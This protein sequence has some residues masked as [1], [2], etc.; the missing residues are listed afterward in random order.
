MKRLPV[1]YRLNN[2]GNIDHNPRN[3]WQGLNDPPY[4]GRHCWFIK[5]VY[6]IRAIAVL[7]INY[8]DNT[9]NSKNPIDTIVEHISRWAPAIE[10]NTEAYIDHVDEIHPK[11][12]FDQLDMHDYDDLMPTVKG[13]ILH[14]L[15]NPRD[16]GK[17]EW[18]SQDEIDEGLRM[19]GVVKN[20]PKPIVQSKT[21]QGAGVSLAGGAAVGIATVVDAAKEAQNLVQP[22]T[23]MAIMLAVLIVVG[24][25]W[26]IYARLR[27]RKVSGE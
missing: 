4:Q 9:K 15:G 23:I 21:I 22:G 18:F 3:H 26:A 5:G 11:T 12:R 20:T 27:T 8:Q 17:S 10:N 6:G 19:A 24:S 2:P 7:L 1:G 25:A 14:E 13:I 16:Y